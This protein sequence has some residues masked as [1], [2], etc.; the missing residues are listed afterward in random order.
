MKDKLDRIKEREEQKE[1]RNSDNFVHKQRSNIKPIGGMR[2]TCIQTYGRTYRHSSRLGQVCHKKVKQRKAGQRKDWIQLIQMPGRSMDVIEQLRLVT[3]K[4][5]DIR[6]RH[7]KVIAWRTDNPSHGKAMLKFQGERGLQ[8]KERFGIRTGNSS[9]KVVTL[10]KMG[11]T[12]KE[13]V[14]AGIF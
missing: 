12:M 6:K 5:L 4:M 1:R 9:H 3:G 14:G 8:G 7:T 11:N 2:R 13:R 10:P